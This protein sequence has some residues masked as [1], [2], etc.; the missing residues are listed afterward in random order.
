MEG[1]YK[2]LRGGAMTVVLGLVVVAIV[3][4]TT[5][6]FGRGGEVKE[7]ATTAAKEAAQKGLDAA[8][9]PDALVDKGKELVGEG[10]DVVVEKG[11]EIADK[12]VG[13]V[14][15]DGKKA[16]GETF[17]ET[18][19]NM[20]GEPGTYEEYSAEK[21]AAN[22][23]AVLDFYASWCPSCRALEKNILENADEIPSDVAILKVDYDSE[24][25][26]KK[27]YGVTQQHTLVQVD[28]DG[29]Q[30]AKWVGSPTLKSLVAKIQ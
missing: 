26:L 24:T 20:I 29:N 1:K 3:I 25:E 19:E 9:D 10:T 27:K 7:T 12:K 2:T 28:K 18:G 11:K 6:I 21:I 22:D 23:G 30:I 14:V 15:E 16:I 17:K 13:D 4:A 8:K 5:V